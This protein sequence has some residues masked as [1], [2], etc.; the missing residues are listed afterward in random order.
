MVVLPPMRSTG[1][2][3]QRPVLFDREPLDGA[4]HVNT[5]YVTAVGN[6]YSY[7]EIFSRVTK[8]KGRR[9]F[10]FA[11]PPQAIQRTLFVLWK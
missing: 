10:H 7:D 2:R 11:S 1:S 5:S 9:R 3:I 4:L 6:D 8:A